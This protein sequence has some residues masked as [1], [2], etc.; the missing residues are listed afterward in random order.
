M[1]SRVDKVMR[2]AFPIILIALG[3]TYYFVNPLMSNFP[4]QCPWRVLTGTLCP[5]CGSQRALSALVHGHLGQALRY[6]YFFVISIPY[7]VVAVLV[8]WYNIG[9][10]LDRLKALAFHRY[11]LWGYIMLFMVWWIVRNLLHI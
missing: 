3:I 6:N 4:V 8:S 10:R 7:A 2:Y 11:T 5:S 9:H 1:L